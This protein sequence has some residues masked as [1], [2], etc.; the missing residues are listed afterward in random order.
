MLT[1]A[2]YISTGRTAYFSYEPSTEGFL[3]TN[4]VTY[5][6][7]VKYFLNYLQ[8]N[9]FTYITPFMSGVPSRA[10]TPSDFLQGALTSGNPSNFYKN[11]WAT[12]GP[13]RRGMQ[14]FNTYTRLNDWFADK[15]TVSGRSISAFLGYTVGFVSATNSYYTPWPQA[16]ICGT[17][18]FFNSWLS[19]LKST[20]VTLDILMVD[21]ESTPFQPDDDVMPT[22]VYNALLASASF[23][24]PW[25]GLSSWNDMYAYFGGNT[26]T[27]PYTGLNLYS[28][29][30]VKDAYQS[31]AHMLAYMDPL[32]KNFP[33]AL[34]SNYKTYQEDY[35]APMSG[36][37]NYVWP[38]DG[39]RLTEVLSC[40]NAGAP[41]LY[42]SMRSTTNKRMVNPTD[43]KRLDWA[44]F[45]TN[46][47]RQFNKRVQRGPWASFILTLVEA[48]AAKR[49]RPD[50][51]LTPWIGSVNWSDVDYIRN[52]LEYRLTEGFAS[53][54]PPEVL[55]TTYWRRN[56]NSI[57]KGYTGEFAGFT[58][59]N[60]STAS[61]RVVTSKLA[62]TGGSSGIWYKS[63]IAGITYDGSTSA[64]K[65]TS[66]GTTGVTSSLA[67]YYGE[68]L[69]TS[70]QT[71]VFSYYIDLNRGFTALN[72]RFITW[73]TADDSVTV[74][75]GP[76]GTTNSSNL[77][78][79]QVLPVTGGIATG[80][81]A[82]R[83]NPGD[84]GWT[85]V[86]W[87]VR[88]PTFTLSSG[89]WTSTTTGMGMHVYNLPASANTSGN[90]E[91]Y[92]KDVAFETLGATAIYI[93]PIDYVFKP[94]LG[95][96]TTSLS[97]SAYSSLNY[98]YNGVSSGSTYIF[99]YFIN[100]DNGSTRSQPLEQI[101]ENFAYWPY[102]YP[103]G[104]TFT[105]TLPSATGPF[106][107]TTLT[108]Y[109]GYSGWVEVSQEFSYINPFEDTLDNNT[110]SLSIFG[111]QNGYSV[112]SA[113]D[114]ILSNAG[115]T[116]Y[117]AHPRLQIKGATSNTDLFVR[118]ATDE[119]NFID[120]NDTPSI[121]FCNAT[122]GY[123][124]ESGMYYVGKPGNSAYYYDYVRQLALL[125]TKHF[126]YFNVAEFINFGYTGS[127]QTYYNLGKGF[128]DFFNVPEAMNAGYTG[129]LVYQRNLENVLK[130]INEKI[131]GFTTT[132]ADY[133]EY[134]W[135]STYF[136]HGAPGLNG[137]TWWWRVTVK[138]GYTMICDGTTLSSRGGYPIGTW[139]STTG[140]TLAGIGLTWAAWELPSEP[141]HTAA[142]KDI[143]FLTMNT[144]ADLI[145]AG[146]TFGRNSIGTYIGSSGYLIVG[147]TGQ[148]R[149]EYD[150]L[151]LEPKGLLLE[152]T[153]TNF[154]NWS[155]SFSNT[156]GSNNNWIDTNLNRISGN[157]SPSGTTNAIRF[158]ATA[159]NA[160]LISTNSIGGSTTGSW[161]CWFR[162]ITGS[163]NLSFTIN[164]GTS[165]RTISNLGTAW[166]RFGS[167]I[168]KT[169][170]GIT[171]AD[172]HL[173]FRL[174][175]T[176]DSVEIW[177]AQVETRLQPRP[178]SPYSDPF[179]TVQYTS[180]I[181]T[182]STRVSRASEFCRLEGISFTSVIGSTQGTFLIEATNVGSI[183]ISNALNNNN[184]LH[185]SVSSN[186]NAAVERRGTAHTATCETKVYWPFP[187]S[188]YPLNMPI[189][190]MFSYAPYGLKISNNG[191][192]GYSTY[193]GLTYVFPYSILNFTLV[194][195]Q[196][197]T[198]PSLNYHLRKVKYWNYV[199]NEVDMQAMSLANEEQVTEFNP[200]G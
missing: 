57:T 60:G 7:S 86:A 22:S 141:G 118:E 56:L 110:V 164:G 8:T 154:L 14:N 196:I 63:N 93:N 120:W 181:P 51:P 145:A 90:Y 52:Y 19:W 76:T 96:S 111:F 37:P 155:E 30:P 122:L 138:P 87:E 119:Y 161:S 126:G 45:T 95:L 15:L 32:L 134:D 81:T 159:N 83:F 158:V 184:V 77:T 79:R 84:S 67:L 2:P 137:N 85:K 88:A 185:Y 40:G 152:A 147:G 176:N 25:Q 55:N 178:V 100:M 82:I 136:A 26:A 156:G 11:V 46:N 69:L 16:G 71:Y 140:P 188:G 108:D 103:R 194:N 42:G 97:R 175:N 190:S 61:F 198:A 72:G 165:W 36:D 64:F 3:R 59:W 149:F 167:E 10:F 44:T 109:S 174:G 48:R 127:L 68:P 151:T 47:F 34:M 41:E 195:G 124:P 163:E 143:N 112:M 125:G 50:Q 27:T 180:Y 135:N 182:T 101:I 94:K 6:T 123:N 23:Y 157:T 169:E 179:S 200:Y 9:G 114:G 75:N 177:G 148:P 192:I 186:A 12:V 172:F 116:F 13:N 80:L 106:Y 115:R 78:F 29:W 146:L 24:L 58:G 144:R 132:T 162:G 173:G 99:S 35:Y 187:S 128:N 166:K 74:P 197:Y 1:A 139:V 62:V 168:T 17:S 39:T 183:M 21:W 20:G 189:K 31:K 117:Y 129:Y 130:E 65:I 91:T 38:Q 104:I 102:L 133:S 5:F 160:S 49:G 171:F 18:E 105:R 70:G 92:I 33:N 193:N 54:S 199:W 53:Q 131:G 113:D 89:Q 170:V 153:S 4:G 142:N 191:N 121:G 150:P 28:W 66:T 73:T 98:Y 43:G 107:N